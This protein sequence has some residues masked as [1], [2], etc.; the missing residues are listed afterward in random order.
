MDIGQIKG[1]WGKDQWKGFGKSKPD[2]KGKGKFPCKGSPKG[3]SKGK[4]Y[5]F[6]QAMAGSEEDL[7]RE[8]KR[9]NLTEADA[10]LLGDS[11]AVRADMV[12]SMVTLRETASRRS[13]M[14]WYHAVQE[15][16][17]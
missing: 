5:F 11:K 3:K 2:D 16:S 14:R 9:E 10:V 12:P 15:R 17:R 8:R 13:Q 1:S 7:A 6:L 4:F